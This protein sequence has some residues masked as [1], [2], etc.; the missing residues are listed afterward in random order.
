MFTS[1]SDVATPIGKKKK[2]LRGEKYIFQI[3]SKGP[4]LHWYWVFHQADYLHEICNRISLR[5]F[6]D[7]GQLKSMMLL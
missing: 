7:K 3:W 5:P 2:K 6:P 1:C 4:N